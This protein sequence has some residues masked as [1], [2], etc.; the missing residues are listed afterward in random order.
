M[1]KLTGHFL[2][3]L[4]KTSRAKGVRRPIPIMR[5][6]LSTDFVDESGIHHVDFGLS[7]FGED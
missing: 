3:S 4:E 2:A 5:T 6:A 1:K 7:S